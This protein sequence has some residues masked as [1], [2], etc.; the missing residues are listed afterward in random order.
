MENN[1]KIVKSELKQL[2]NNQK[3]MKKEKNKK[4]TKNGLV[5]CYKRVSNYEFDKF[6][7]CISI[8]LEK[9]IDGLQIDFI[10]NDEGQFYENFVTLSMNNV[11]I[12]YFDMD[13]SEECHP[14]YKLLSDVYKKL[15]EKDGVK[16]LKQKNGK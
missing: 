13:F 5:K 4:I 11:P 6:S 1:Q 15:L 8:C 14:N 10:V 7:T 3:N 16:K 9:F 12:A 2:K